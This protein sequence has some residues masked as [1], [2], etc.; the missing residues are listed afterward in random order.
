LES[1]LARPFHS[2]GGQDAYPT[3]IDKATALFH[4]MI[5]NHPF[6]NGNKRT[7]VLAVD[8]FLLGN[9]YTLTLDNDK[10]Y[11]LANNTASYKQRGITHEKSFQEIKDALAKSAVPLSLFYREQK[12]DRK[13]SKYYKTMITIRRS[14]RRSPDNEVIPAT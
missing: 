3:V 2:A 7:A 8:A 10:M 9:G 13:M 12:K 14:V 1:A 11:E 4:S 5:A 6:H